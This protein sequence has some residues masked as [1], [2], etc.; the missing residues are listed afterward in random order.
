MNFIFSIERSAGAPADVR[1]ADE[2][3]DELVLASS[4][5]VTSPV[6]VNDASG[7]PQLRGETTVQSNC[8]ERPVGLEI[9]HLVSRQCS[10]CSQP[11]RPVNSDT[12][13]TVLEG[14]PRGMAGNS[15]SVIPDPWCSCV[16]RMLT[17]LQT[18]FPDGRQAEVSSHL[19]AE[20]SAAGRRNNGRQKAA[21]REPEKTQKTLKI[22]VG[23]DIWR[24]M[25]YTNCL[26]KS[27]V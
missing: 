21:K 13:W 23:S 11:W 27:F 19:G 7:S 3:I 18:K 20:T 24:E 12:C 26:T 22:L 16:T 9:G 17:G 25:W 10:L 5:P 2:L 15:P 6:V 4:K 1:H 8:D 14:S